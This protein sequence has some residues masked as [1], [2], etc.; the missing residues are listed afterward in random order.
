MDPRS[1]PVARCRRAA[2]SALRATARPLPGS[3]SSH[4]YPTR[5]EGNW[6]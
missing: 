4:S 2:T 1:D 3:L 5:S 6:K